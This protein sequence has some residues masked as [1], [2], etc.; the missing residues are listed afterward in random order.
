ML[1]RSSAADYVYAKT[2]GRL[3]KSFVGQRANQLFAVKSLAELWQLVFNT[4][5]PMVPEAMLAQKLENDARKRFIQEFCDLLS[6]F[7]TPDP[8]ALQL[9]RRFDYSNLKKINF[10]LRTGQ[11]SMPQIVD[12]GKFSSIKYEAWPNVA[13][14]TSG[15]KLS[16][17][18]KPVEMADVKTFE[19]NLDVQY[20][21]DLWHVV[22]NYHGEDKTAIEK[23][24]SEELIIDNIVWAIR[25]R[26]YFQMK[27]EEVISYL[28][29]VTEIG[30]KSDPIAGPAL[31]IL[32]K[33][34]DTYED[35][36]NWRYAKF[37]NPHEEGV[38][39]NVDPGWIQTSAR[40]AIQRRALQ[41]FHR[42]PCSP[43]VLA[44]WFKIK[45]QELDYIRRAAEGLRLNVQVEEMN[46]Y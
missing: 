28:A 12:I 5:V 38:I 37:L 16:W 14:M 33:S 29:W 40:A 46:K 44:P 41:M 25:L 22:Q 11:A 31:E 19:H 18:N 4:E 43:A 8:V 42:F 13:E 17:F 23:L 2:S 26:V 21:K 20:V 7:S 9:L 15:T 35:W 6:L 24:I 34:L 3:A 32:D 27:P 1:D 30:E 45:Q 36:R 39:W 10:A